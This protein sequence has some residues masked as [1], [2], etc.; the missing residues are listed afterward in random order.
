MENVNSLTYS[1]PQF[2]LYSIRQRSLS[3]GKE[4][5]RDTRH[6]KVTNKRKEKEK[7]KESERKQLTT[8]TELLAVLQQ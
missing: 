7:E 3:P 5:T 1:R 2:M 8:Q 6:T 4:Q